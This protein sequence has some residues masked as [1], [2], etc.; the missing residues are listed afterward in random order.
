MI[1]IITQELSVNRLH[2]QAFSLVQVEYY[3]SA[4]YQ[5]SNRFIFAREVVYFIKPQR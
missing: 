3:C 5:I 4:D 1:H 2:F